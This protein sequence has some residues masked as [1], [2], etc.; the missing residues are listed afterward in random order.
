MC[1]PLTNPATGTKTRPPTVAKVL[2]A[3][4][5]SPVLRGQM[6]KCEQETPPRRGAERAQVGLYQ[7]SATAD[8]RASWTNQ[9]LSSYRPNSPTRSLP[10][11]AADRGRR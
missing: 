10:E 4:K 5:I 7:R 3:A 11:S 6:S 1:P 9:R 2:P 8:V